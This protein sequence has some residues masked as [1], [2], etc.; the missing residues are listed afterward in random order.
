MTTKLALLGGKPVR[1][2]PFPAHP[3]IGEEEKRAVLEV[4]ESGRLSTFI[5]APGEY[6]QGGKTI[7]EF[8]RRFAEY[9][10]VEHAVAFNSA[11]AALHAAVVG[12]GVEAGEE[13]IVPPYTFTST[14]TCALMQ[15]AIPIF[16]DIEDAVFGLDPESVERAITLL[17]RAIILVHLFGHPAKIKRV[18]EIARR[19]NLRVIE[20]CAQ[21]PGAKCDG[22]LVGT[23]G[24]CGVF[25][26]TESK[27]ITTGEGGMLITNNAAI[28]GSA[29][30]VRNHGEMIVEGQAE[31]TYSSTMLG[32]NYRM[33]EMEAALGIVQFGRLDALNERRIQLAK[34]LS[35]RVGGMEG[36]C[37]PV[38]LPGARHVYYVYAMKYDEAQCGIPRD[39]FVK[40]MNAE[41]IPFSA[42]YV[43]P[44]YLAP[45]YQGRRHA[46]FQHYAGNTRYQ[47][48]MC[49]TAERMHEREVML[50]GIVRFPATEQDMD[51]V[52]DAMQKVMEQKDSLCRVAYA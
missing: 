15:N 4:L 7:K 36:I 25:S 49:P 50:T 33:T 23:F 14:A 32:W 18:M 9:H 16:A 2:R 40:A 10:G 52:A 38:T 13:V 47:K 27:T 19:H 39:V 51:D 31:R 21:A 3:V 24:D 20:D 1:S 46:A 34:H 44:L 41:G 42:G 17:T 12:V 5:A 28:A 48:G 11:T 8:E 37:A 35:E 45:L 43:R 29:R 26:F 22:Q 6:F 30:M